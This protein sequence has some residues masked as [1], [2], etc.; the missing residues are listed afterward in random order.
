MY[1][2]QNNILKLV[3]F[4]QLGINLTCSLNSRLPVR[5]ICK[6]FKCPHLEALRIL[7]RATEKTSR[8]ERFMLFGACVFIV[9]FHEEFQGACSS[10]FLV[11]RGLG[12]RVLNCISLHNPVQPQRPCFVNRKCQH[13]EAARAH[14]LQRPEEQDAFW[15]R[16]CR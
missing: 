15:W 12:C 10:R 1:F 2:A 14:L 11:S 7:M 13:V 6:P 8:S 4:Q 9:G 5:E 16:D 3:S